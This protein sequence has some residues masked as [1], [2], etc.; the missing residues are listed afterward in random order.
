MIPNCTPASRP[1]PRRSAARRSLVALML[2]FSLLAAHAVPV[3][4]YSDEF[5]KQE[6]MNPLQIIAT[7]ATPI[8]VALRWLIFKPIWWLGHHQPM[9]FL[10]NVDAPERE[11]EF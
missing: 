1:A 2:S 7:A 4:A 10:F 8:G 5:K 9:K 11:P 3:A 6:A